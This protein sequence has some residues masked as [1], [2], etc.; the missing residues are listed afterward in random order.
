MSKQPRP[1]ANDLGSAAAVKDGLVRTSFRPPHS[2]SQHL[3]HRPHRQNRPRRYPR[4]LEWRPL[5]DNSLRGFATDG[6]LIC[7][8]VLKWRNR[9][10]QQGFSGAVVQ[11]LEAAYGPIT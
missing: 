9:V 1:Q 10:L 7:N 6:K 3:P 5:S 2:K 8:P 11:D 4:R